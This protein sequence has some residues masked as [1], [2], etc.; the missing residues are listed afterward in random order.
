M[1]ST[2]S[3]EAVFANLDRLTEPDFPLEGYSDLKG[4]ELVA[5]LHGTSADLRGYVAYRRSSKQVIVAFSGTRTLSQSMLDCHFSKRKHPG[6]PRCRVHRGFWRL[7]RGI[8]DQAFAGVKKALDEHEVDELVLTGHSMGGAISYLLA[9]DLLSSPDGLKPGLSIKIAVFG[10]PRPG[11]ARLAEHWQDI[12]RSYR[13]QYGQ[14]ALIEYAVKAYNDGTHFEVAYCICYSTYLHRC[15]F[16]SPGQRGLS[17]FMPHT[18][19]PRARSSLP[20]PRIGV[21]ACSLQRR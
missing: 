3:S 7:Y 11:D 10:S 19:L 16:T 21:G 1:R 14:H 15:T 13:A 4:T 9:V 17:S 6:N 18:S 8:A 5:A 12:I 20:H 2:H